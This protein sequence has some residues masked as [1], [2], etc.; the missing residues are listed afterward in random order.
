MKIKSLKAIEI[1]DSRGKPTLRTFV[2]LEDGS[3]YSS[4]IPSGASVGKYEALELRDHDPKR[5]AGQ[6]VLKAIR[7]VNTILNEALT[8]MEVNDPKVIDDKMRSIDATE[9]KSRLGANAILSAS[10]AV[11]K[12]AAYSG[13]KTLWQ[14]INEYY[15]KNT[16]PSFP[17]IMVNVINGGKHAE[18]NFDIQEFMLVPKANL[19]SQAV[20]VAAE[21]FNALGKNLKKRMLSTLVGDEGGYSPLLLSN[22]DVLTTM[23]QAAQEC[24]YTNLNDF[25]LALDVAATEFFVDG[26]YIMI[27][28]NRTM[29]PE[30]LMRYYEDIQKRYNIFVFE[31]P[32]ADDDWENFS[33]LTKLSLDNFL[34]VGDDLYATNPKRIKEGIEMKAT[35]TV[36]IKPNQ[37]GTVSETVEAIKLS[38][39]A[40]WK[41]VISHRSGETEDSFIAD[42]SYACA[43]DFFK[44]GSMCRSERLC[45]Y[46]RLIEIEN[47]L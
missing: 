19:P 1:L 45:K 25:N 9:N 10:Q 8:G 14:F 31:D 34:V 6:G 21:I 16:T 18:W 27:K 33:A 41:I 15:F 12:A 40:G 47:Q 3:Y 4:S 36:L 35:N 17:R 46:N 22:E 37:I 32:F 44:C 38:R 5:F 23:L 7:H 43:A 2:F 24:G 20:K 30:E 29:K 13:K 11:V 42:F 26:M 28:N 39:E